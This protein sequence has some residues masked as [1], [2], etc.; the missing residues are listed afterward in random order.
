VLPAP[1]LLAHLCRY[2]ISCYSSLLQQVDATA[3]AELLFQQRAMSP[4]AM[5]AALGPYGALW[6]HPDDLQQLSQSQQGPQGVSVG[7]SVASGPDLGRPATM[8]GM[9]GGPRTSNLGLGAR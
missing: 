1:Y 7:G 2:N 6:L 8:T 5:Q 9:Q 4:A 3:D